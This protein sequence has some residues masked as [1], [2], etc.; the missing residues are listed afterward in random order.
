MDIV[1]SDQARHSFQW[2]WRS[3][4]F[5][6]RIFVVDQ[7]IAVHGEKAASEAGREPD[8]YCRHAKAV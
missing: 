7:M 1:S 4:H 5:E 3:L 2:T 6:E 8:S